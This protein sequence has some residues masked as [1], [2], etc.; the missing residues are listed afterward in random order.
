MNADRDTG[1]VWR[2]FDSVA[3]RYD[4]VN[5]LL[6]FRRDVV[7]RNKLAARLPVGEP[8]SILD[9][10]TGTGDVL[11]TVARLRPNVRLGLGL[12][13]SPKML[14]LAHA[15]LA[16]GDM[17]ALARGDAVRLPLADRSVDAVT[18]AF[19]IRNVP[20]VLTALEEIR[21]VLKP[22][23]RA[24]IL[25]FSQ[26]TNRLFRPLYLFYLR[27]VLPCLGGIVSRQPHAYRYLNETIESFPYGQ[28]F[29]DLLLQAGFGQAAAAPLTLGIAT[30]Y[31]AT[32]DESE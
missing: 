22:G 31:E 12:D 8:F 32:A 5:R 28:V 20:D 27:K 9:V 1:S 6:S 3:D 17:F 25:E 13:M 29:C 2:M 21:R 11:A 16:A 26:P 14:D 30:L 4:L 18:M 23:G 7:W 10:A 24:L 19:G 15:K